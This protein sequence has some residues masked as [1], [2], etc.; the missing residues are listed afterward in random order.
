MHGLLAKQDGIHGFCDGHF[1]ALGPG[2]FHHPRAI[3]CDAQG[4]LFVVDMTARIQR[5]SPEGEFETAWEM[6]AKR[7]GK[8]TGLTVDS[9]GR[10]LVADTHYNRVMIYDADGNLLPDGI[11]NYELKAIAGSAKA[12]EPTRTAA[13]VSAGSSTDTVVW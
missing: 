2:Q 10:V 12:S 9:A 7:A 8:P 1:N 5:F 4:R 6:P 3:A 13:A 11:Y